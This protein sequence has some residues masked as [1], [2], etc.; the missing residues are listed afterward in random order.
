MKMVEV[1]YRDGPRERRI[2]GWE[3]G[4]SD[5][6]LDLVTEQITGDGGPHR[7]RRIERCSIL[8]VIPLRDARAPEPELDAEP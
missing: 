7:T 1:V 3:R 5:T 4:E 6:V 2:M 8:T